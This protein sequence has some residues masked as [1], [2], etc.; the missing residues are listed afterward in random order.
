MKENFSYLDNAKRYY[1]EHIIHVSVGATAGACLAL[2]EIPTLALGSAIIVGCWVR[3]G[4]E[5]LRRGDTP[6]IDLSYI[7][8]GLLIS[9]VAILSRIHEKF[10]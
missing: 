3:Q 8:A 4:L 1:K 2:G 5:F 7:H 10:L 9:G 6:G